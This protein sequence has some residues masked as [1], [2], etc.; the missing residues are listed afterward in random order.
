MVRI[1][2]KVQD[3]KRSKDLRKMRRPW[4]RLQKQ[5]E[6]RRN[7]RLRRVSIILMLG[8]DRIG[9]T[10]ILNS[11]RKSVRD[12]KSVKRTPCSKITTRWQL[13]RTRTKDQHLFSTTRVM[14]DNVIKGDTS[15]HSKTVMTRHRLSS[16]VKFQNSW[17][18]PCLKQTSSQLTLESS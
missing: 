14:F 9:G 4:K 18:P 11:K 8:Q 12:L 7:S 10:I 16:N 2:T 3:L 15:I 5:I 17:T 13:N 1:Q 6:Q